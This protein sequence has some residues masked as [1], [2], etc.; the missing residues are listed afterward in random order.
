MRTFI[1]VPLPHECH[2]LL[3]DLQSKMQALDADIRWTAVRSIHLTLKFLGEIDPALIPRLSS[4]L[5]ST[6]VSVPPFGLS[7]RGLGGFPNL[8]SPRVLWC[9]V[10][11]DK[12]ELAALQTA[13]EKACASIGFEPETREFHPHLT[14]GRVQGKRNLQRI[15]DY[16]K[17]GSAF[18]QAFDVDRY[19]VY[20]SV[21]APRGAIYSVLDTIELIRK[22]TV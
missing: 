13:V 21:L 12:A 5:R 3:S 4:A 10:E 19:H 17:I 14:L 18:E 6:P 2:T 15:L 9:G 20:R 8:R 11:G 16:I 22:P 7:L 1:A